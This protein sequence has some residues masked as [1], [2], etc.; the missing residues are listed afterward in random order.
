[1]RVRF[2]IWVDRLYMGRFRLG[3]SLAYQG[4]QIESSDIDSINNFRTMHEHKRPV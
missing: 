2:R 1:M 4:E 3:N